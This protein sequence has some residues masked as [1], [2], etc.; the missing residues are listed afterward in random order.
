MI[1]VILLMN[2]IL[3]SL[4]VVGLI[5]LP[6]SY[7]MAQED[8]WINIPIGK[9]ALWVEIDGDK[10]YVTNPEDGN[11]AIIDINS[12]KVVDTI[13]VSKGVIITEVVSEKNRLYATVE[14][15]NKV[16]VYDLTTHAQITEIDIGEPEKVMF[17]KSDKPYGQREYSTFQTNGIGLDYNPN[18]EMLYVVHS[19]AS[20]INVINTNNNQVVETIIV[21]TTPLLMEIDVESNIGYVTNWES[22]TISVLD[23]ETNKVINN[24]QTGFA[25][26]Q[27]AIDH[28]N[29][30]LYVTHEA[31][32]HVTVI[33]L[34]DSSIQSKIELKGPTHAVAL[35]RTAGIL[36]VTYTPTSGVT[37]QSYIDRVE[38][39][40][41]RTDKLIGGND[42]P[43]NPFIIRIT[44]NQQLFASIINEGIVDAID[45]SERPIYQENVENAVNLEKE[46]DSNGG[47]CLIA[48]AAYG[49]E[50]APQVQF[51][52]EIRDN[53]VMSTST[54]ASFMTGFNQL[55]YSFSPTIADLERENPM[56]QEAVR[57]F[58]TPMVST[59]SIMTLA[60]DGNEVEV[61]GLGISVIVLNL[62][63][64]IAAPTITGYKI[65]KRLK[66]KNNTSKL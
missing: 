31:S 41:T 7:A 63:M 4:L 8:S 55:Y 42:I 66:S 11:I 3:L 27:M 35:D 15:K 13:N 53:I 57:A 5:S 10:V 38:F 20:H 12:K 19:E 47:G 59:L 48:T 64:Y 39:I 28:D 36:H 22:S 44:D 54:G 51:L 21:G 37:G 14:D 50:L 29:M 56:F 16:F 30:K 61:L 25:P 49:T 65:H 62:G 45:L 40:D 23:L 58:I 6:L 18:N 32:S 9:S 46:D 17:S 43:A 52:R 1:I 24:L 26:S 2:V 33:N 34:Q 60:E